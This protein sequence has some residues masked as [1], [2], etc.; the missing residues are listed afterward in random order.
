MSSFAITTY[1]TGTQTLNNTESGVITA[2]GTLFNEFVSG[3]LMNGTTTSMI[4][5]GAV[6]SQ[7]AS[8]VLLNAS[9]AT[10]TVG[11]SGQLISGLTYVAVAGQVGGSCTL[12]NAGTILGGG[13]MNLSCA[14][15]TSVSLTNTGTMSASSITRS[16]IEMNFGSGSFVQMTNA[17]TLTGV[18]NEVVALRSA[19]S[20]AIANSG[21]ISN[22]TAGGTAILSA[23]S[24]TL[25]NTGT[26]IG[27]I[28]SNSTTTIDNSGM[29]HGSL[30][31]SMQGD[32][33]T[34]LGRIEGDVFLGQGNNLFNGIGGTVTGSVYGGQG[35]DIYYFG[36]TPERVIDGGG[37]DRIYAQTDISL[38]SGIE[39]VYL[40]HRPG[41]VAT[42]NQLDNGMVAEVANVTMIGQGGNDY[43]SSFAGNN[44]LRGG[45]GDDLIWTSE[46]NDTALGGVG[47]DFIAFQ[48]GEDSLDGG[49]GVDTLTFA[50]LA[51]GVTINLQT[52]QGL[53]AGGEAFT[54]KGFEV[55][56]GSG[57]ADSVTGNAADNA[58]GTGEGNDT[59]DG[60][61]GND[62]L[63]AGRGNDSV[64]GGNGSDTISGGLDAD[65]LGGGAGSDTFVFTAI[66]DS[67]AGTADLITDFAL[68]DRIDLSL[69]DA[70]QGSGADDA[71]TFIG[72]AAFTAGPQVRATVDA[73]AGTT[74][75]EARVAGLAMPDLVIVLT[76]AL[77][78]T[79]SQFLL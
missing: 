37:Y 79:A 8:A 2:S 5:L 45:T 15:L 52:G 12:N 28:T 50:G 46:G 16:A 60:G 14:G 42:G 1:A 48:G 39:D 47:N 64:Q 31:L 41:L 68:T 76:G 35:N 49:A 53:A 22:A 67:M 4:A 44:L 70:I 33:V 6:A 19:G 69:I 3:V 62:Q 13:A 61:A 55:L 72:A 21:T 56:N 59:Q 77:T 23:A 57:F 51:E 30:S 18:G 20:L 75:I 32:T 25:T 54:A 10:I 27:A 66:Q 26:I 29:I 36:D 34:N 17:G 78:L 74:T 9:N 43:I 58:I 63:Y 38:S 71:F 7:Y 40:A 11:Q 24:L 73:L 65:T